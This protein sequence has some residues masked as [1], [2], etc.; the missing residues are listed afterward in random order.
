MKYDREK[1]LASRAAE[2]PEQRAIRLK[3]QREY[4]RRL[5][6]SKP[7]L[8][9]RETPVQ[10]EARLKRQRAYEARRLAKDPDGT[11]A[12]QR[13]AVAKWRALHPE[14]A[15]EIVKRSRAKPECRA[16]FNANRQRYRRA[17]I[18]KSLFWEAKNRAKARGV[19][20]TITLAGIPPMGTHCPLLG[21]PFAERVLGVRSPNTPSL[22]RIDPTM[23]YVPGNVWVVG[24]R[25]NLVK[26][27]GTAE[28]HAMIAAAMRRALL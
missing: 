18:V 14:R 9:K 24:Y 4:M 16:V 5:N 22:D 2:T 1:Y 11:R 27:D 17:N 13:A 28:E 20:F 8:A 3:R 12:K 10:R 6:R 26:N 15:K 25:A 23:G 7:P 21:H 19:E